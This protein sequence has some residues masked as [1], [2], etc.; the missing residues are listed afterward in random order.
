M[1]K[2]LVWYLSSS[3]LP[4]PRFTFKAFKNND[5]VEGVLNQRSLK[6]GNLPHLMKLLMPTLISS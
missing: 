3:F 1:K 4:F 2:L 5:T 6:K